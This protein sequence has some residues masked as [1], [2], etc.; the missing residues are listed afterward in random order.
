MTKP[1]NKPGRSVDLEIEVPGTPEEVWEAI[2]TGPG[3]SIWFV[4]TE[5][6]ERAGGAVTMHHGPGMDQTGKVTAW[7]PPRRFA[8]GVGEWSPTKASAPA[9][10]ALELLVEARSGGTCVVRL[11]NSGFGTGADWD[12]A[13]EGTRRGWRLCL[14]MLRLYLEHFAG[15]SS[16]AFTAR[17]VVQAPPERAFA[18]L[19]G[20]LGMQGAVEGQ[21]IRA[22]A[23]GTPELAGVVERIE[24]DQ[25]T[26]LLDEPSPGI[27][28]V[29]VGG[30]AETVIAA[31]SASLFGDDAA[32]LTERT[33]AAWQAWMDE[34]F[35]QPGPPA[36]AG[37]PRTRSIEVEIEVPG[38]PEQVW[39]AIATGPGI[40]A[41]FVPAEVDGRRG[42]SVSL[43]IGTGMEPSGVVSH[44]EPPHRFA[45]EEDWQPVEDSDAGPLAT[46]FLVEARAG[47]TCIVRV[48]NSVFSSRDEW[49]R[50]LE[51]MRD[52]WHAY[53]ANLALYMTHF[54]GRPCSM[55]M[56]RGQ[57]D[58]PQDHAWTALKEALGLAGAA[59][60]DRV[61]AGA[62][63]GPSLAGAV[64]R[65]GASGTHRE[66]R[67]L[68]DEPA[69]GFALV[70]TF[71]W[72]EQV[73]TSIHVH[74]FGE[75][76]AAARARDQPLWRAW[77]EER[78]P[79]RA[80]AEVR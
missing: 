52:G 61:V 17:G 43:D 41:W 48:V 49:D 80:A 42:G 65:T 29:T 27:G 31:V 26:L 46:E 1:D 40:T 39:E 57:A 62:P 34:R 5:V 15:Q 10:T 3:I 9:A 51:G 66:L 55:I 12:Q 19:T 28:T 35:P 78:F 22:S 24:D 32:A 74:L 38:T 23:P 14:H 77:M 53:L 75:R 45:Y 25:L 60:G 37:E 68:L 63:G 73:H 13:I 59:K 54:A 7:E 21:R 71:V 56:A 64:E 79:S 47:G 36:R 16:A 76:G 2:A 4:P 11:V 33:E 67:I 70:F 58:R 44:W 30:P 6:E 50:E 69:P 72:Q 8:F 18:E 20:A